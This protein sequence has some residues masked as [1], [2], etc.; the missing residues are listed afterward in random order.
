M[1]LLRRSSSSDVRPLHRRRGRMALPVPYSSLC[2]RRRRRACAAA[3]PALPSSAACR[4]RS[5]TAARDM[6]WCSRCFTH[7]LSV[8]SKRRC[9]LGMT[10]SNHVPVPWSP[11]LSVPYISTSL[12]LFRDVLVRLGVADA[13]VAA[14][15][16][17]HA[18]VVDVH[19]LA[20]LPPRLDRAVLQRQRSRPARSAPDRTRTSCPARG[21]RDRPRA[22]S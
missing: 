2:R 18:A 3:P 1:R 5:R 7:S 20:V 8:F 12:H 14:E 15:L 11:F 10:P 21:S 4:S 13:E 16:P 6:Y 19:P 9:R 17:Q 22:A